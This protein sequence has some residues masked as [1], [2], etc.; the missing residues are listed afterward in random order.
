M[1]TKSENGLSPWVQGYPDYLKQVLA[2]LIDNAIKFSES[3]TIEIRVGAAVTPHNL[4]FK[5]V[6]QGCG[7][8]PERQVLLNHP[9]SQAESGLTRNSQG[10][11][12][13]LTL[14]RQLVNAMGGWMEFR[15]KPAEGSTFCFTLPLPEA[16]Q[17]NAA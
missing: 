12:M 9:V 13:G 17:A 7:I 11:G 10:I 1:I 3:G 2:L 5:I 15:S 8:A 4:E 16:R 6:D 14:A